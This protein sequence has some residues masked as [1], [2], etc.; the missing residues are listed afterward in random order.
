MGLGW[1][2]AYF[3]K[4]TA[5]EGVYVKHGVATADNAL[6]G[7][8]LDKLPELQEWVNDPEGEM[9]SFFANM[10]LDKLRAWREES[11]DAGNLKGGKQRKN[12]GK[13]RKRETS[14]IATRTDKHNKKGKGRRVT[15]EEESSGD[16]LL[17]IRPGL[18]KAKTRPMSSPG[19]DE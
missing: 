13:K 17:V 18:R 7:A 10:T 15:S 8:D 14:P 5:R 16:E 3:N 4:D 2:N 12:V 9:H 1:A 6:L 19:S 11:L